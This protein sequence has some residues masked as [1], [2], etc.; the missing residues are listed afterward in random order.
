LYVSSSCWTLSGCTIRSTRSISWIWKR[1]VSRF[2]KT[3]VIK[4][5][6][7][8]RRRLF[9][10]ITRSR[11]AG[12]SSSY[13]WRLERSEGPRGVMDVRS[14]LGPQPIRFGDDLDRMLRRL[15]G[16]LANLDPGERA[17]RRDPVGL[18]GVHDVEHGPADLHREREVLRL[19]APGA[20]VPRALL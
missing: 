19:H 6:R 11:K 16:S 12:R 9:S 10:A 18:L 14:R 3:S 5:P 7:G 20:V 2:S 17:V 8:T 13:S 15:P 1:T 4:G